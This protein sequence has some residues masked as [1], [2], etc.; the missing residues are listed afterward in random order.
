[1]DPNPVISAPFFV[2]KN[3]NVR[4]IHSQQSPIGF[5]FITKFGLE[6]INKFTVK[7]FFVDSTY[8]TNSEKWKCSS[9]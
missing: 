4:L 7:E 6:M 3:P 1:M 2:K 5:G 9:S 8:K